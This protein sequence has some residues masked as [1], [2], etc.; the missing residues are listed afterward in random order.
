MNNETAYGVTTET[1]QG[2]GYRSSEGRDDQCVPSSGLCILRHFGVFLFAWQ[3]S[4]VLDY[5]RK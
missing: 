4:R 5:S 1:N 3:G 2:I